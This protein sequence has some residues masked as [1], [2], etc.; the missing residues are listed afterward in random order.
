MA[1]KNVG[2]SF[3]QKMSDL[4]SKLS[5]MQFRTT[6]FIK[7]ERG[8]NLIETGG[9]VAG[10]V[11]KY[12]LAPVFALN[13]VDG[14]ASPSTIID[15][16]T[17]IITTLSGV[18]EEILKDSPELISIIQNIL[19]MVIETTEF[20]ISFLKNNLQILDYMIIII[21]SS[22]IIFVMAKLTQIL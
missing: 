14:Q 17:S 10:N 18:L 6:Q 12:F 8:Q 2:K 19:I 16:T 1:F 3:S 11:T 7:S 13:V 5:Q 20:I 15:T 21:P 9:T 4:N 22:I